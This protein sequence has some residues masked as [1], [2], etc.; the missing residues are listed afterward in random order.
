MG[1]DSYRFDVRDQ[2]HADQSYQGFVRAF[3]LMKQITSS[4]KI[5]EKIVAS[6]RS[7]LAKLQSIVRG[8]KRSRFNKT[9]KLKQGFEAYVK[10]LKRF[11]IRLVSLF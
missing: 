7:H 1:R 9:D 11:V 5:E 2:S 8:M 6:N 10:H 3:T 4:S